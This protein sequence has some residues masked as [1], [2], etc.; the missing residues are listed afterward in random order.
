MSK[1]LAGVLGWGGLRS[2]AGFSEQ[3]LGKALIGKW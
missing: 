1:S 3:V 2:L